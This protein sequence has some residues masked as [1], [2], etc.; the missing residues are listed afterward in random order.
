MLYARV[1]VLA[2]P[3]HHS[4]TTTQ[5]IL[6]LMP[7]GL[8]PPASGTFTVAMPLTVTFERGCCIVC[9]ALFGIYVVWWPNFKE[10]G[11]CII[12]LTSRLL[13]KVQFLTWEPELNL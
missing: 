4:V 1:C 9:A 11:I 3:L 6:S 7:F 12:A 2:F 13:Q 10:K 8:L 5:S